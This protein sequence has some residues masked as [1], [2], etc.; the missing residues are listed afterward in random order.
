[1]VSQCRC[2]MSVLKKQCP[3]TLFNCNRCQTKL[4]NAGKVWRASIPAVS[5]YYIESSTFTVD[6]EYDQSYQLKTNLN[7]LDYG[8]SNN[9]Y[10]GEQSAFPDRPDDFVANAEGFKPCYSGAIE[11]FTSKISTSSAAKAEFDNAISGSAPPYTWDELGPP[12]S[13]YAINVAHY[14]GEGW[15]VIYSVKVLGFHQQLRDVFSGGSDGLVYFS[16]GG[17]YKSDMSRCFLDEYERFERTSVGF[18]ILDYLDATD[19]ELEDITSGVVAYYGNDI[20]AVAEEQLPEHI[21][22]KHVFS[23]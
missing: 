11:L 4:K 8:P 17:V 23:T 7:N 20:A 5:G 1:M 10:Q 16:F 6:L 19:S 15:R 9:E 13:D 3:R 18:D 12:H 2:N 14:Y 21:D 22:M